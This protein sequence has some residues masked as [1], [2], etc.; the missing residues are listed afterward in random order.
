MNSVTQFAQYLL[1]LDPQ[2]SQGRLALF[3]YMKH[4]LDPQDPFTPQTIENFYARALNFDHW[5]VQAQSLSQEVREDLAGYLKQQN[6]ET[7]EWKNIRHADEIQIIDLKHL[8][9]FE[10]IIK[11]SEGSRQKSGD[12]IKLM[13]ISDEEVISLFLSSLGTL[14]V[15]VF[16]P[17]AMVIG[18]R[19]FPLAPRCHLHYSSNMELMPHVRHILQGS[20]MTTISFF[21]DEQG[22]NGLVTRGHT[23]QKFE[24]FLRA[25]VNDNQDLFSSLKRIERNFINPQSDPYYQELVQSLEKANRAVQS[26]HGRAFNIPAAEKTLQKGSLALRNAFPNDRLLQLLVTHLEYGIRHAS[27]NPENHPYQTGAPGTYS[28]E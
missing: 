24:T 3:N 15:Q 25:R 11:N 27:T 16:G 12:K 28:A 23:F 2:K 17:K 26:P 19:L 18:A 10:Q 4:I 8:R 5:Q 14:E 20:M 6:L 21:Q 1:R 9:D 22:L 7:P 13:K